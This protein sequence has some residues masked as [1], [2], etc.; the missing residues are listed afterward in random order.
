LYKG[1]LTPSIFLTLKKY[2]IPTVI[3]LHDFGLL[4]PHNIHLDGKMNICERCISGSTLNCVIHK[5]NRNNLL[6][7]TVSALEFQ[8]QK[9]LF[10]PINVFDKIIT[11]SEFSKNMHIKTNRFNSKVTQIYNF[12]PLLDE[13]IPNSS[14][15]NYL[16][17]FGRLSD[18]KGIKTLIKAWSIR[19][20]NSKLLIVGEGA[21][22][23]FCKS[24]ESKS[25]NIEVLG[26]KTGNE[27][28]DLISN[29]SFVIV[30]SECDE[31][32]PLA[33]VESYK[34]GKPVIG[35]NIGGI[36]ELI[37]ENE[38]GYLFELK[39]TVDLDSKICIAENI[40]NNEYQIM[41]KNALLFAENNF[42]ENHH[43]KKLIELY[44][45]VITE[46]LR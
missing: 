26:Y 44:E 12:A 40:S 45:S 15:G 11:V 7:S 13:G 34:L 46:K 35:S 28:K 29:S 14:K 18:E 39:N 19:S 20:R 30:P 32:N 23:E 37:N 4:C 33:I 21:L 25:S 36:P 27:L 9:L 42:A 22:Y 43:Y 5:C 3:T 16:L 38:T 24:E 8:Y 10:P 31:N 1:D 2:K 6:L 41:S 17:F